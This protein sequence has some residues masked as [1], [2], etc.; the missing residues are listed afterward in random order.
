MILRAEAV[1]HALI[2][3]SSSMSP[4]LMSPG[5]VDWRMKTEAAGQL[6]IPLLY[7]PFLLNKNELTI[8]ISHALSNS[9]ARLLI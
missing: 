9:N 7:R 3:I 1:L 5:A 4:S 2:M 8:F 6:A